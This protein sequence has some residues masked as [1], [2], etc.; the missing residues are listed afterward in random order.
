MHSEEAQA[1]NHPTGGHDLW[2]VADVADYL[3]VSRTWVYKAAAAGDLPSIKLRGI[4]RFYPEIIRKHLLSL[5]L[6]SGPI[7]RGS[8]H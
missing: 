4:I 3:R 6:S 8:D 5:I 1:R 2:L 7:S